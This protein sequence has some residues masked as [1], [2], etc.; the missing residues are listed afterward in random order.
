MP[1]PQVIRLELGTPDAIVVE[2]SGG[3]LFVVADPGVPDNQ[4]DAV[5][6]VAEYL[7]HQQCDERDLPTLPIPMQ[8]RRAS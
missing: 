5:T 7:P 3:D 8:Q 4:L 2:T 1:R 6:R